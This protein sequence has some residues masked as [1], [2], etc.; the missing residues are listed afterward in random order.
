MNN[1]SFSL[2]VYFRFVHLGKLATEIVLANADRAG[3]ENI[4]NH[5]L[6]LQK[7]VGKELASSDG[8]AISLKKSR[9]EVVEKHIKHLFIC[10]IS[11]PKKYG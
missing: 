2:Y 5:L 9:Q 7:A 3:M 4:H 6:S 11:L 10:I 8:N 1:Q